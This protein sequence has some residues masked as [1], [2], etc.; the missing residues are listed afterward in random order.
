MMKVLMPALL[1]AT[2]TK[3]GTAT[4]AHVHLALNNGARTVFLCVGPTKSDRQMEHA[5]VGVGSPE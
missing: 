5:L 2:T 4:N 3:Y 1:T